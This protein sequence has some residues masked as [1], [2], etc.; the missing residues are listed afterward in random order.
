MDLVELVYEGGEVLDLALEAQRDLLASEL[1]SRFA[2]VDLRRLPAAERA[3]LLR[4]GAAREPRN[5]IIRGLSGLKEV[6][7]FFTRSALMLDVLGK[8]DPPEPRELSVYAYRTKR[9]FVY[10][11]DASGMVR[12]AGIGTVSLHAGPFFPRVAFDAVEGVVIGVPALSEGNTAVLGSLKKLRK[13]KNLNFDIVTTERMAGVETVGS[14]LAVAE[15]SNL[16]VVPHDAADLRGPHEGGILALC[17]GRALCTS[18]TDAFFNLPYSS[19]RYLQAEKFNPGSYANAALLY[20]NQRAVLDAWP[21]S[22]DLDWET[23]PRE[24]LRRL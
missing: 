20:P 16:L 10:G 15:A 7:N 24:I 18:G 1:R 6:A 19:G 22:H 2:T 4:A 8:S 17:A 21:G 23:V 14:A 12:G 11:K 5:V 13:T 3:K 9:V